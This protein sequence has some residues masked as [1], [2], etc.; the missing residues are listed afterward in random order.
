MTGIRSSLFRHAAP[1]SA[2]RNY[3][4]AT[5]KSLGQELR[6]GRPP[7]LTVQQRQDRRTVA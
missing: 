7:I 6:F 1:W 3:S 5:S 4:G 2:E